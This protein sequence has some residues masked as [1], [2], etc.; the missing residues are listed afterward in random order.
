MVGL[1]GSWVVGLLGGWVVGLGM[2]V[3]GVIAGLCRG[4]SKCA[5]FRTSCLHPLSETERVLVTEAICPHFTRVNELL[6]REV[7]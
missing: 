7:E 1:L 5:I 4:S 3:R 6:D 2:N